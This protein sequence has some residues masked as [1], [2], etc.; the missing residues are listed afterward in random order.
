VKDVVGRLAINPNTVLKAYRELEYAGLISA[1]PLL[2]GVPPAGLRLP[3]TAGRA[4]GYGRVPGGP[5]H[6]ANTHRGV[7][8][9]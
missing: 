7:T 4:R 5:P 1:R 8:V 2:V 6:V 9:G 3:V